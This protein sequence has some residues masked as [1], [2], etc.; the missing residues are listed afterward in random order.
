MFDSRVLT[1]LFLGISA[2]IPILLIFGTLSV[3]L[4]EA[5]VA[6]STVTFFSWAALG[7]SFKY[8]WAPL[9]DK[10]PLPGL[11]ARLG[12]RRSWL[13]V[14]QLAVIASIL[15]MA[16]SDPQSGLIAVAIGAV[17]LGF[18]SA[19]QDIV[20]DAYRIEAADKDLQAMMA[21]AYIAGYR[22]GMLIAGAGA[23]KLASAV[24]GEDGYQ[25]FAWTVAYGGMAAAMLIGVATTLW[26]REPE[27]KPQPTVFRENQDYARFL[28]LFLLAAGVFIAG[29][30]VTS[31]WATAG[32]NLL[33]DDW[34][35]G[36]ALAGFF[37][38]LSR[39]VLCLGLAVLAG[40]GLVRARLVPAAMVRETYVAP[41][42]DFLRRYGKAGLL[43]LL[44]I[45]TYRISDIVL[46]A[47]ANMFYID[48][49]FTKDQIANIAKTFGLVMTIVGGFLG[50]AMALMLGLNRALMLGAALVAV[51][52][53]LFALLAISGQSVPMLIVVIAADSLA[54]GLAS[55]VFV[56]YLSSLTNVSFTATQYALFSSIMTLFPKVLAGYSGMMVDALGYAW[57]FVGAS[58]LGLPVM[59]LVALA[60]RVERSE[61]TP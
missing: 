12:R 13:L 24:G 35:W 20:I 56:A 14:S 3:W 22:V 34:G 30:L 36:S 49:G 9:V 40:W 15:L 52:N 18:S 19:T 41:F 53:L 27:T 47:V 17:L 5:E 43:L 42:A 48:Q 28:G 57:F 4:R 7:Y 31:S 23:L 21:S 44:L 6:R 59:G 29:F 55:A 60:A 50:G 58:L 61:S 10:L 38:E 1:M 26:I 25:P 54:G 46:G 32:K 37:V 8:L 16:F 51:T 39:L 2:G 11:T 33:G 45:G